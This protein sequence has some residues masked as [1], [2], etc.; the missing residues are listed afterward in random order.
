MV[1]GNHDHP[2]SFGKIH[3]LDVFSTVPLDGIHVFSKPGVMKLE[4]KNGLVQIVGIPWPLR[5]NLVAQQDHRFKSSS[6]I[7]AYISE[8]VGGI[9]ANF[10]SELDEKI[11]AVLAG[12][13]TVSSGLFSGSEK[14]AI[15]GDDPIF[16][17]SQLALRPFDYVALGH[18]HRYQNLNPNGYPAVVYSGSTERIDFGERKEKKGFC[19]VTIDEKKKWG[20]RAV[21][22][23][24][25]L[26]IRPMI[27]IE[28][29]LE[30]G[31]NQTKQILAEIEK[32]EIDDAIVKIVYHIGGDFV[33]GSADTVD[34]LAIQRACSSAMCLA[35][36]TPV[37]KQVIRE[38]RAEL[39][40]AMD[41]ISIIDKYLKVRGGESGVDLKKVKE[42][43]LR[44]HNELEESCDEKAILDQYINE[45]ERSVSSN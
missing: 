8:K 43:A 14:C 44:M 28:V 40:V 17:P 16:L 38:R 24:V 45:K 33:T 42:K 13:L 12:H 3:A 35:S 19:S 34:L 27:Q 2:L 26:S 5:N 1:V 9:I 31:K 25:E 20:D 4:T 23:F 7:A 41:F 39:S 32:Y 30:S 21:H 6:E 11:P 18:L 22:K 29:V 10:A 37:R 15:I 36:L